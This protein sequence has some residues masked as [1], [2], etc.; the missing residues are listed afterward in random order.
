MN[1]KTAIMTTRDNFNILT[2]KRFYK[3]KIKLIFFFHQDYVIHTPNFA[4]VGDHILLQI[5]I[6]SWRDI[7]K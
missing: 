3:F 4:M 1:N 7:T 2:G 5:V 6:K